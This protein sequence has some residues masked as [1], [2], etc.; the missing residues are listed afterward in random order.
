MLHKLGI[1][2]AISYH[3]V[4]A[5][6]LFERGCSVQRRFQKI[7]QE[8][9]S[10][11]LSPELRTRICETGLGIA[12]A[13]NYQNA[14]TV[15]FISSSGEFYFLEMNTRL[16]VEHPVTEMITSIELIAE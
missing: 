8:T 13:A 4:D 1:R 5:G 9:P 3:E 6:P 16:Q 10:L 11:A 15:E 14:G 12:R 7:I 2:P